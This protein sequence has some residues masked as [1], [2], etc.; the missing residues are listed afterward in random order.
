MSI[1]KK[2]C[3]ISATPCGGQ[4]IL[5]KNRD[6]N[7]DP[8][9][10]VFHD[11][12]NGVE[13]LYFQ[14]ID[15]GWIEGVNEFGISLVNSALMVLDDEKDRPSK[16]KDDEF[17]EEG[18]Q[19]LARILARDSYK[20]GNLMLD[21]LSSTT[22]EE[23]V[24]KASTNKGVLGHNI[25]S[26][27]RKTYGVER[28]LKGVLEG[29]EGDLH[30]KKLRP[31]LTHVRT[32][33]GIWNPSTGYQ[34]GEN[35]A[36]SLERKRRAQNL[37]RGIDRAEDIGPCIYRDRLRNPNDPFNVSRISNLYTSSHAVFD[38]LNKKMYLYLFPD[39]CGYAGFEKRF[40]GPSVC[41]FEIYRYGHGDENGDF[42]LQEIRVNPSRVA[43][44]YRR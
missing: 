34:Y 16:K 18:L 30:V 38:P 39:C 14:D 22:V 26:D 21:I 32:N 12:H 2:A 42:E 1:N 6:R 25:I 28:T 41:S 23:A 7:Y 9:I 44:R 27:G 4:T 20:D 24:K 31:D 43:S 15:T 8:D 3:T 19:N 5:F 17:D 10:K 11:R 35:R 29:E 36:S 13:I 33:H 37:L 40:T